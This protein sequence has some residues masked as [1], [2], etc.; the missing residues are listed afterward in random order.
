M[1]EIR[2]SQIA[3]R[4]SKSEREKFLILSVLDQKPVSTI[5]KSLVDREL[6]TRKFKASEIRRLPI[7]L[8]RILLRQMTEEALPYYEKHK[9]A[10]QLDEIDDGIE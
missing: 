4:L 9:S 1:S 3:I 8:R 5:L 10:L 7:E 2:D 6:K